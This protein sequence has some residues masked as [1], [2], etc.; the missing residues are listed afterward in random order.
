MVHFTPVEFGV[1]EFE[2]FGQN[3]CEIPQ[4]DYMYM[5]GGL[6]FRI[7]DL[8]YFTCISGQTI[9]SPVFR[10]NICVAGHKKL[11]G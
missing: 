9:Q 10:V 3:A 2:R 8:R 4:I 11:V 5:E 6:P 7:V 1:Q